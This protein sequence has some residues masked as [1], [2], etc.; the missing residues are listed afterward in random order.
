MTIIHHTNKSEF[1]YDADRMGHMRV[2]SKTYT[3]I[4]QAGM[5][6]LHM[7]HKTKNRR[8]NIG[9]QGRNRKGRTTLRKYTSIGSLDCVEPL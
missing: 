6:S 3:L 2:H 8:V 1:Y 5:P 4:P 7:E 9:Y